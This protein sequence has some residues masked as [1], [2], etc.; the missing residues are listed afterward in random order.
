VKP[1]Q[2]VMELYR[3]KLKPLSPWRTP[4]HADTLAGMLCWA[5]ARK[6][7]GDVL[8][9]E[10]IEP[11]LRNQPPFVLSDAFPGELLPLPA[12]VHLQ[13]WPNDQLKIIRKARW[14]WPEAF[15]RVQAGHRLS[16]ADL[17][18][19][20]AFKL[21]AHT[22]NMLDRLTD[23]TGAGGQLFTLPEHW[24]GEKSALL[25]D[26]PYLSVYAR[27]A[28]GFAERLL[29]LFTEVAQ[30]GFGA[31]ASVGKGQ[32]ELLSGLEPMTELDQVAAPDGLIALSTF[33]PSENDPTE[34]GWQA[35]TKFGKL[36]PDFGLENVF[37][38]PLL[39][40]RPGAFFHTT[41]AR[42]VIGRAIPMDQ[43]LASDVCQQL[44]A[45]GAEIAHLAFGLA[46][47]ARISM[48]G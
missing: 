43:L 47:P 5:C 48:A 17:L 24:L 40:L 44:R 6:E 22:R 8:Q 45:K 9:R 41:Q 33:Q 42:S 10:I 26:A 37:K 34:G 23:T 2:P 46:V 27:V 15:H 36:G 20:D 3:L 14:L 32:F 18:P 30:T 31:D 11:A 21:H 28:P 29:A 25:A 13:N 16:L 35:F 38:R 39:M 7:G 12:F 19:D 4:W 1:G